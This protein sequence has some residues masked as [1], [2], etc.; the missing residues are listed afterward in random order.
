M[1]S[2]WA[3]F[4]WLSITAFAIWATWR[5][6]KMAVH[7][8]RDLQRFNQLIEASAKLICEHEHIA[9]DVMVHPPGKPMDVCEDCGK[10]WAADGT[11]HEGIVM[12]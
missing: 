7:A 1:T 4:F 3:A 11:E 12:G 6:W 9:H 5:L 8:H 10:G 2:F